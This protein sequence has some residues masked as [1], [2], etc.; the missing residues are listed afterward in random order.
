MKK[1]LQFTM[2]IVIMILAIS[3]ILETE[4]HQKPIVSKVCICR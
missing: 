3:D 1:T 2:I 4:S